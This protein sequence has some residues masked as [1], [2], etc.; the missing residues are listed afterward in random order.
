VS[1]RTNIELN[2]EHLTLNGSVWDDV[3]VVLTEDEDEDGAR[4]EWQMANDRAWDFD[5][6]HCGA[7][8]F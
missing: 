4:G 5:F 2:I 3:E 1:A 7:H 8:F 6:V